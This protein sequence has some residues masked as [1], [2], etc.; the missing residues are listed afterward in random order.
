LAALQHRLSAFQHIMR[1]MQVGSIVVESFKIDGLEHRKM[2]FQWKRC[3]NFNT[4][5]RFEV[6][7]TAMIGGVF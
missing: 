3:G 6:E 1:W 4:G 5:C 2:V 7:N